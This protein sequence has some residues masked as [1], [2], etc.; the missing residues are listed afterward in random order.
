MRILLCGFAAMGLLCIVMLGVLVGCPRA[1]STTKPAVVR[2]G[3]N[4]VEEKPKQETLNMVSAL[5]HEA[6]AL[7]ISLNNDDQELA[8]LLYQAAD[9]IERL[10][11]RLEKQQ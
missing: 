11:C 2:V 3:E 9:E 1:T 10:H 6:N 5:R 7:R 4:F 8:T